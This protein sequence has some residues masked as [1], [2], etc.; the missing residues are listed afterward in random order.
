MTMIGPRATP[1]QRIQNIKF[2]IERNEMLARDGE[3][4]AVRDDAKQRLAYLY[5]QLERAQ[6][7]DEM[8]SAATIRRMLKQ[9]QS[10][11]KDTQ[12]VDEG[13]LLVGITS[14][15]SWVLRDAPSP[16][17]HYKFLLAA[18]MEKPWD[19]GTPAPTGAG[20]AERKGG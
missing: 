4:V 15:L 7:A 3:T 17:S 10:R 11:Q 12:P 6:G 5:T 9:V 16:L 8:K 19:S 18:K 14:A 2:Q 1:R 13:M 20:V